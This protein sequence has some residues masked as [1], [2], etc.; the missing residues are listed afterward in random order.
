LREIAGQKELR[1]GCKA[2][3]RPRAVLTSRARSIRA[4]L[5]RLKHTP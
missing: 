2:L 5:V 4:R 1:D 3:Q